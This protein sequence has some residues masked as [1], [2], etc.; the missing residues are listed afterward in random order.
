MKSK[1][2]TAHRRGLTGASAVM[3]LKGIAPVSVS[4]H[5]YL[6]TILSME[7]KKTVQITLEVEEDMVELMK[8]VLPRI[9]GIVAFNQ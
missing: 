4:R 8:L 1:V 9:R 2:Y 3:A 5:I 7:N 6:L